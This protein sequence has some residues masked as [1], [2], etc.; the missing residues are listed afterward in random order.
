MKNIQFE[1]SSDAVKSKLVFC[2]WKSYT[3]ERMK[4]IGELYFRPHKIAYISNVQNE[5]EKKSQFRAFH[6]WP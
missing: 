2:T 3:K 6:L 4:V 1:R 5:H